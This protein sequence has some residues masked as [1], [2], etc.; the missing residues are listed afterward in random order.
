MS[1]ATITLEIP[2]NIYQ[3][4]VDTA[5]ATQRPLEEIILQVFQVGSPPLL[6]DIPQEFKVELTDL[7]QLDDETLWKIATG[8]K[9]KLEME[10]YALLI[11]KS[12]DHNLTEIEQL[13]LNQLRHEFD[14]FMLRK[15]HS[16]ALLRWRGYQI[17][18]H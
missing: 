14:I 18:N 17:P 9:T 6:D 4:L 5:K 13:K 2:E 1:K 12:K 10:A 15:A 7:D 11:N 3:R 8:K 16:A